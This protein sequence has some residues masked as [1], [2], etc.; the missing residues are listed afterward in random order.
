MFCFHCFTSAVDITPEM[1]LPGTD[2]E[3][4]IMFTYAALLQAVPA[5]KSQ[6]GRLHMRTRLNCSA[7]IV[8][9]WVTNLFQGDIN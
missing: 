2:Y 5:A 7:G 8:L 9:G 6:V 4:A 1:S 3:S